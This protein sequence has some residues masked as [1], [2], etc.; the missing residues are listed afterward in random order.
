ML[1]Q[2]KVDAHFIDQVCRLNADALLWAE[3]LSA[4]RLNEYLIRYAWM[5]FDYDYIAGS[6]MDEYLRQ[7]INSRREYR[8]SHRNKTVI[9]KAA[10]TIFGRTREELKMM[11]PREL[12]RLYRQRA[13][14][15]HPDKGGDQDRFVKLSEAYHDLLQ[16]KK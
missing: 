14:E 7:F 9:L 10:S 15:L 2:D 11:N 12:T 1:S 6:L 3:M 13:H 5:Y 8:S 4:N 16:T